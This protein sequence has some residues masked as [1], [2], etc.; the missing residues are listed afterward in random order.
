MYLM[1]EVKEDR[2]LE[3]FKLSIIGFI[4]IIIVDNI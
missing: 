1:T 2:Y 4:H 3:F